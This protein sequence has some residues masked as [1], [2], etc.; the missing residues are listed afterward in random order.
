MTFKILLVFSSKKSISRL[1]QIASVKHS[2]YET[3]ILKTTVLEAVGEG[4]HDIV[5]GKHF[6]VQKLS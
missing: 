1:Y 2:K 3:E 5:L 6:I 4:L